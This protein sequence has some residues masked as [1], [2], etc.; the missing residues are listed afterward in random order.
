MGY[1]CVVCV[2]QVP[3]TSRIT[4]EAMKADGTV[5]RAALPTIFNPEDLNA[6]EAAL[7]VRD[8]F[9]G[10]VTAVTMGPPAACELLRECLFRGA[11]RAI[12]V[13]DRRAA[14]SDT[15]ATSYILSRAVRTI[16][17]FDFVFCGRQAIDGDTAQVGPQLAEKLGIP[18]ITYFERLVELQDRTVRIRRNVGNGWEVLEARLPVLVTVIDLANTPRPWAARRT[19]RYKRARAPLEVTAEVKAAMPGASEAEIER[20][21]AKRLEALKSQGLALEQWSLDDIQAD[22]NWCGL[23]GSPTK[24]HRVQS[25]VLTKEGYTQVEP[26]EEGIRK[27]IHELVVDRTLG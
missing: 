9:G 21:V 1:N 24:V 7:D 12:L 22:L 15:L 11:D 20:E 2:K 18:Q 27:M 14:A 26:T 13:T 10:T 6:L 16:G 3:D 17:N 5:N 4:G 8:R 19:M 25:I 23:A